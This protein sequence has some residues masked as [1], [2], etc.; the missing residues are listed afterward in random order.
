MAKGRRG[1]GED[2]RKRGRRVERRKDRIEERKK[3][4]K[5]ER[6]KRRKGRRAK[7][8]RKRTKLHMKKTMPAHHLEWSQGNYNT[9]KIQ[10]NA[11]R[12]VRKTLE[13]KGELRDEWQTW[14]RCNCLPA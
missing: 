5:V 3:G 10:D 7:Q 2:E 8:K 11:E 4:T 13:R 1:G 6:N 14:S 12:Y 9:S